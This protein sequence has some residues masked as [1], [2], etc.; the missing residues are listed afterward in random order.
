MKYSAF[1]H[2]RGVGLIELLVALTLSIIIILAMLRAFVVTGKVTATASQGA[3]TDS[4]LMLG[5]ITTDRILQGIGY[6][7]VDTTQGYGVNFQVFAE[8][9]TALNKGQV[10][11]ILVWK[12]TSD[13]CQALVSKAN[14]LKIFGESEG[15][16]CTS[17]AQPSETTSSREIIQNNSVGLTNNNNQIGRIDIKVQDAASPCF[18]FGIADQTVAAS[19]STEVETTQGGKYQVVLIAHPY[20]ASTE[21]T[22][23]PIQN[24]TCL[25]NFK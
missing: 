4:S 5:L 2:Q 3:R 17:L 6:N 25:F 7:L 9:G 24:I 14:S 10:G 18:P 11:K 22:S 16:D 15:Y 19:T 20:A 1:I 23:E 8:D 21:S 12:I 13:K